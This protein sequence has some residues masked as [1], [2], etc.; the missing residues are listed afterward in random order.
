MCAFPC[1]C[2]CLEIRWSVQM[3]Q[4]LSLRKVAILENARF[5]KTAKQTRCVCVCVCVCLCVSVCV[6]GTG[7]EAFVCCWLC[8]MAFFGLTYLGP[9]NFYETNLLKFVNLSKFTDDELKKAFAKVDKDKSGSITVEEVRYHISYTHNN[10]HTHIHMH[11]YHIHIHTL[12]SDM[13]THTNT[14]TQYTNARTHTHMHPIPTH[15]HTHT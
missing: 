3:L 10:T 15:T 7:G 13:H 8:T 1:D 2:L 6:C 9:A 14:H 5:E 12:C 11:T 4:S